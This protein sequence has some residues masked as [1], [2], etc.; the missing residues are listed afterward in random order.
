MIIKITEASPSAESQCS[1]PASTRAAPP[2]A[3][4][5]QPDPE[6]KPTAL[7]MV[8]DTGKGAF[9]KAAFENY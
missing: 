8:P 3:H 9:C 5:R 2:P 6:R 1:P 7:A 4:R